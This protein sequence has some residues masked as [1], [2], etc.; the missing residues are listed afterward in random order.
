MYTIVVKGNHLFPKPALGQC[1][2]VFC[3]LRSSFPAG[4]ETIPHPTICC[5]KSS[6]PVWGR[7]NRL[8]FLVIEKCLLL[9]SEGEYH[10]MNIPLNDTE[11]W[12]L[13]RWQ[14][15]SGALNN[16]QV[17]DRPGPSCES[18]T[19]P[20]INRGR[21]FWHHLSATYIADL[22]FFPRQVN[23]HWHH[24]SCD[25]H[26]MVGWVNDSCVTLTL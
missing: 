10:I 11:E 8:V 16:I 24:H 4:R 15:V 18:F 26:M 7:R 9:L 3:L 21:A 17:V 1:D 20:S 19:S 6:A 23:T 13:F 22:R 12:A 2:V 14:V 5:G 25:P